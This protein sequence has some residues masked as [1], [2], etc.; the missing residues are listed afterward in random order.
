MV[1]AY[2]NAAQ[3]VDEV[4]KLP[5]YRGNCGTSRPYVPYNLDRMKPAKIVY[6]TLPSIPQAL[7][8]DAPPAQ[9]YR[10]TI[11]NGKMQCIP[12]T[13]PGVSKEACEALSGMYQMN[14]PRPTQECSSCPYGSSQEPRAPLSNKM[15]KNCNAVCQYPWLQTVWGC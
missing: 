13:G 3:Q 5:L 2:Q 11:I 12:S 10:S 15:E 8:D 9:S 7:I 4:A 14:C 1:Y 6:N